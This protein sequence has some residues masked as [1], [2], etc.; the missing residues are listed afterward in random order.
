MPNGHLDTFGGAV[1]TLD[2][3]EQVYKSGY[4]PTLLLSWYI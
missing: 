4:R 3:I 1:L 2:L